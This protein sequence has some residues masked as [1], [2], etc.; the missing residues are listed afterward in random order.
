MA[1]GLCRPSA[2]Q[3]SGRHHRGG[4]AAALGRG[5]PGRPAV[6]AGGARWARAGGFVAFDPAD[7]SGVHVDALH[8]AARQRGRGI[9]G[10]LLA[11]VSLSAKGQPVWLEVLEGNASARA[12]YA[13][14]GGDEGPVF[15]DVVLGAVVP[16]RRV[17]WADS[18]RLADPAKGRAR[19]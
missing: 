2:R 7:P 5:R 10:A 15:E 17:T 8:V 16:A 9:G 3:R 6:G 13:A 11:A 18:R 19:R 14:W 1:T 4:D 12:V